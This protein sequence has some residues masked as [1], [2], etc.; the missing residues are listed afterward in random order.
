MESPDG[1]VIYYSRENE[2]GIWRV[3]AE[4]GG[5]ER[6]LEDGM[7]NDWTLSATGIYL[8]RRDSSRLEFYPFGAERPTRSL[9]FPRGVR[10]GSRRS[11]QMAL[12]PDGRWILYTQ[13]DR[14]ESDLVLMENFR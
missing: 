5:E 9:E 7:P 3:P 2:K 12:S 6:V 13:A 8:L 14:V 10:F 11:R 1:A 4:G